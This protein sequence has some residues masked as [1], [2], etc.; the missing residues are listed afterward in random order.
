MDF[1]IIS[2]NQFSFKVIKYVPLMHFYTPNVVLGQFEDNFTIALKIIQADKMDTEAPSI[3][4]IGTN[5][6]YNIY[7]WHCCN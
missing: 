6:N 4:I 3:C 5:L 7:I 2:M 1:Q